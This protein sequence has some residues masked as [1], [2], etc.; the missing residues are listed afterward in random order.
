MT[1][2]EAVRVRLA[3]PNE[4]S[5]LLAVERS[6]GEM[7]RALPGLQAL[8]DGE[9]IAE[10]RHREWVAQGTEWGATDREGVP[11]GFL[12]GEVFDDV[13]HVWEM[14]VH[15]QWQGRGIG[16]ALMDEAVAYARAAGL[17]ALTLTTFRDVPWNAP[18]YVRL[19]FAPLT[20]GELDVRLQ[21]TLADEVAAGLPA[22][23]RC[24]MQ[25]RLVSP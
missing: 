8:A 11:V 15:R 17:Q 1:L 19:G 18:F 20:D 4:V 6:A 21:A 16:R 10:A 13:L 23:R 5:R 7:F 25:R 12:A 22:E 14:S 24:A 9:P 3:T 2:Q